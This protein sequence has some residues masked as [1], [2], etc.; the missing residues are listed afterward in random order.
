MPKVAALAIGFC[1]LALYPGARAFAQGG[2]RAAVS[3]TD[4]QAAV[5][6]YLGDGTGDAD[7][8]GGP[9]SAGYDQGFYLRQGRFSLQVHL[10]L[11]ARYE[12]WLWDSDQGALLGAGSGGSLSGFSLPRAT[13]AFSGTA[14]C[15]IRYYLELEFGHFGRTVVDAAAT[16]TQPLGPLVQSLDFATAREAWIQWSANPALHL[17]FGQVS[18]AT[19]RQALVAP[20]L[21]QFVDVSLATAFVGWSMPGYTDRNRDHGLACHG[22]FG[23]TSEWS[24]LFTV[25][26]GDGGDAIR[27][28][29]D[30]RTSDNLAY[31][32][33]LNWAFL[34]PIGYQ[35]GA[36]RQSTCGW[37]GEAGVWGYAYAD[38][39]DRAH[40]RVSDARRYGVDLALGF[41][42]WSLTAAFSR[43]TD[44]FNAASASH[45]AYLL[46]LGY[47]LPGT[48]WELA[49][50][51]DGYDSNNPAGVAGPQQMPLGDG[52]VHELAFAV[53]YFLNGAGNKL[54]LDVSFVEGEEAGSRLL[55]DPYSGAYGARTG[56]AGQGQAPYGALVRFQWQLAL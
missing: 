14:P 16:P 51:Y 37:Y 24:Y 18:T 44:E 31:S 3:A 21:Q 12:A 36:L 5:D 15:D 35:E 20:T 45:T 30:A 42:G 9:G 2:T 1:L 38:R 40:A 10:T 47:H 4:L 13:L 46:Q 11:Q 26:N 6:A 17:R 23:G 28:V 8:V 48:R 49:V 19:T 25:T 34:N 22:V 52:P 43:G 39:V 56:V 53:G 55:F 33:R 29:L 7:L 41:G 54:T 27:N 32:A 50:R